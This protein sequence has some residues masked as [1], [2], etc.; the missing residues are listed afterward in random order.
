[1]IKP[2]LKFLTLSLLDILLTNVQTFELVSTLD[3]N[4]FAWISVTYM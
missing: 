4:M 2:R 3:T 1:M